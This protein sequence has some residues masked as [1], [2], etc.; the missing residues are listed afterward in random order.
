MYR[1]QIPY[2]IWKGENRWILKYEFPSLA[3][4]PR[5]HVRGS[6]FR[7]EGVF[8]GEST[9]ALGI[10]CV[11]CHFLVFFFSSLTGYESTPSHRITTWRREASG[12]SDRCIYSSYFWSR[13]EA[14]FKWTTFWCSAHIL[15]ESRCWQENSCNYETKR[16][17][18]VAM[19]GLNLVTTF[20]GCPLLLLHRIMHNYTAICETTSYHHSRCY[21]QRRSFCTAQI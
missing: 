8:R 13:W 19:I 2:N 1:K 9:T 21:G 5:L 20:M 3:L 15:R 4:T 7:C 12:S 11:P 10:L 17:L 18:T 6:D 14:Y 16:I